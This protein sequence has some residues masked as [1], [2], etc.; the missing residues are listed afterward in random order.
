[1]LLKVK[2][3]NKDDIWSADL[4][5]MPSNMKYHYILTVIDLYTK[6]A[7]AVPLT[8]K[9][10][11][12]V[13]KAFQ[14]IMKESNRKPDKIWVDKGKE[15]YNQ[16]VKALPF[17]I[18]STLNDG[19]AVVVERFNRTL[20]QMMFKKF[21]SQGNQKWLKI[22]PEILERYNNKVHSSIK[23]TPTKASEDPNSIM[24]ITLRNNS[25][26]E[27]TL[28][29]KK[30]KFKVGQRVRIFKWKSKFEK[31]FTAK[32]TREV[33]IIKKINSTVPV[34]YEL[35]DEEDEDIVGRFYENELQATD[36]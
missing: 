27:L 1:M 15:F 25:E 11:E 34:T 6:Y 36:Y 10:G 16:H 3:F 17:E 4:V 14:K 12:T 9:R 28:P 2:V 32:W 21:T 30:P 31:G 24:G 23:T 29:R 22:L 8:N 13:M 7:W 5:E 18:Y 33:F 35:Q 20:K 26:N 19:K